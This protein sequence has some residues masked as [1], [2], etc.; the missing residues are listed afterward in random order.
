MGAEQ[1]ESN[2]ERE[3]EKWKTRAKVAERE[4]KKFQEQVFKAIDIEPEYPDDV[5][6]SIKDLLFSQEMGLITEFLKD[7]VR[8]TKAG[9]KDRIYQRI[10]QK[11]HGMKY[12]ERYKKE[13]RY[14]EY[15]KKYS[16]KKKAAMSNRSNQEE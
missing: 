12:R 11:K 9:I 7:I 3:I 1:L 15:F 14:V 16:K 13:G 8:K 10:Y 5:P 2:P 6:E 4:L